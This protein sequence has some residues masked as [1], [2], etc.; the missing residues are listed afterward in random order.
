MTITLIHANATADEMFAA[1]VAMEHEAETCAGIGLE[2]RAAVL[3]ARAKDMRAASKAE[4]VKEASAE[5]GRMG[6]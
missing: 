4:A 2:R 6:E 1:A 5:H 3:N